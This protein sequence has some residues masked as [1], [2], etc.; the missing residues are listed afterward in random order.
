MRFALWNFDSALRHFAFFKHSFLYKNRLFKRVFY[1]LIFVIQK[2][3]FFYIRDP[4]FFPFVNRARTPPFPVQPS[5]NNTRCLLFVSSL[6]VL[7]IKRRPGLSFCRVLKV[8]TYQGKQS[9]F[10]FTN[11]RTKWLAAIS[12]GDVVE[13]L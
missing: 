5:C 11:P 1:L 7:T 2:K 8:I 12:T 9:D 10:F 4:L 13:I 6:V 3:E